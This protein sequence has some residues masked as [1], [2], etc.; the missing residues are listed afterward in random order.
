M[1]LKQRCWASQSGATWHGHLFVVV[2]SLLGSVILAPT[3]EAKSVRRALIVANSNYSDYPTLSNPL[4]DATDISRELK[5]SHY[6]V[7]MIVNGTK[8]EILTG[9][10]KLV[11]EGD[12]DDLMLVYYAGHG[13]EVDGK[14]YLI[15]IDAIPGKG[16][17][18]FI[19]L[20]EVIERLNS[21]EAS[22]IVM[23]DAC[24]TL[25]ENHGGSGFV[26]EEPPEN[27]MIVF[28]TGLGKS[29]SDG[30]AGQNSPFASAFLGAMI[31]GG[32]TAAT[33]A[34]DLVVRTRFA[35]PEQSP[36]YF[37]SISSR[38]LI[39]GDPDAPA[40]GTLALAWDAAAR[41]EWRDALALATRAALA[42]N[43]D[44]MYAL[45]G[46]YKASIPGI[47]VN[48]KE[49]AKW[50][51]RAVRAGH[52]G[53]E[54]DYAIALMS[55]PAAATLDASA[56]GLKAIAT[57]QRNAAEGDALSLYWLGRWYLHKGT[58][59]EDKV[60]I[61]AGLDLLERAK[62][63]NGEGRRLALRYLEGYTGKV[64]P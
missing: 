38:L 28:A 14:N 36:V 2:L 45:A 56:D 58:L 3:T 21:T 27:M 34:D 33:F 11:S 31:Y 5:E 57:L 23:L 1:N 40:A 12:D 42:G 48:R 17:D 15:P 54:R 49:S 64:A 19:S 47:P 6:Q 46:F 41:Q 22:K 52:S 32:V 20:S 59:A 7:Q 62:A 37:S 35:N 44:A 55:T 25:P 16:R 60:K 43:S 24:R 50:G 9:V 26:R 13:F 4:H 29:A 61:A 51:R 30:D 18:M 53:A 8:S 39:N 10:F 63:G